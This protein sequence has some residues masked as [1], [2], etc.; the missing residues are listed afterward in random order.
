MKVVSIISLMLLAHL[1]VF[2]SL[3]QMPSWYCTCLFIKICICIASYLVWT[4]SKNNKPYSPLNQG[5]L[6]MLVWIQELMKTKSKNQKH[7]KANKLLSVHDAQHQSNIQRPK[8][9]SS[10]ERVIR[11]IKNYTHS[12]S[13]HLEERQ[14]IPHRV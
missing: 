6:K 10:T 2:L 1:V 9:D 7:Q 8:I 5:L 14:D 4:K 13:Q 12:R 11:S 3:Y